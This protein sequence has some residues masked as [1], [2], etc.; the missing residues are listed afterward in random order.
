MK[1]LYSF[2][3]SG[4][5]EQFWRRE[6]AAA[7][8]EELQFIPFNH[9]SFVDVGTILRAQ[10]LDDAY[11]ARRPDIM[12]LY[13]EVRSL[14]LTEGIGAMIV[15]N[16]PP[17]HPDWLRTLDVYKVLR[18]SDG[19]ICAY[20]RDFAYMHAY[21]HVLFHSP[22]YSRD[23][24]MKAKLEYLGTRRADFWPLGLFDAAFDPALSEEA[25][26][27]RSRDV[28]VV[29]VGAQ[30]VGK[31]PFLARIKKVLGRR[32]RM[33]GLSSLKRNVYFNLKF[34]F[35]GWVR[36]LPYDAYVP[37]YQRAKIGFNLHNRGIYTVGNFRLFELPACGVMQISDGG[38]YLQKFFDVGEEIVSYE[39]VDDL[40]DLI[41]YYLKNEAERVRIARNAFRRVLSSHRFAPGL[42][43]AGRTIADAARGAAVR[44]TP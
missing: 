15:D 3:K 41:H 24:D 16:C 7:S 28:D 36:S 23:L 6:I 44:V 42:Q 14:I 40:I 9:G 21:D 34:G 35:P 10:L 18:T 8:T 37:L 1:I 29:F 31:M 12:R 33:Y 32:C 22:A 25:L 2:N 13:T 17:Y 43:Q 38:E 4:F 11:Y 20:D 26:F 39:G 27:S 30:H 19:P 5:E